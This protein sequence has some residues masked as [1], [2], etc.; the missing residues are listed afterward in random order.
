MSTKHNLFLVMTVICLLGF[1]TKSGWA[2]NV[3]PDGGFESGT[4]G[5]WISLG[6]TMSIAATGAKEGTQCLQVDV[7]AG[8]WGNI[9][10]TYTG[11]V[12]VKGKQLR[13]SAWVRTNYGAGA[14]PV[15]Y[16]RANEYDSAGA[17]L[18]YGAN[19]ATITGQVADWTILNVL[20][21]SKGNGTL[22]DPG[23]FTY[24]GLVNDCSTLTGPS[25]IFWD[26]VQLQEWTS[27]PTNALLDGGFELG[28]VNPWVTI[29]AG[30]VLSIASAGAHGGTN[31][32]Q[33]DV[34]A[35]ALAQ[36]T[37]VF[38]GSFVT[39][40][41]KAQFSSWVKTNFGPGGTPSVAIKINEYDSSG[42]L[43]TWGSL[44]DVHTGNLPTWTN[45]KMQFK[46]SGN[47]TLPDPGGLLFLNLYGDMSTVTG[48][49]QLWWDDVR[50]EEVVDNGDLLTNGSFEFGMG[51]WQQWVGTAGGLTVTAVEAA[52]AKEGTRAC[53]MEWSSGATARQLVQDIFDVPQAQLIPGRWLMMTAWYKAQ[54][55]NQKETVMLGR[56]FGD[57]LGNLD[58]ASGGNNG[59]VSGDR[60]SWT[61]QFMAF[62]VPSTGDY[63]SLRVHFSVAT[64]GA[65]TA[66]N[67]YV[68]DMSLM[69][70]TAGQDANLMLNGSFEDEMQTW[71]KWC[72]PAS[73]IAVSFPSDGTA[74]DGSKYAKI[75]FPDTARH[76]QLIF[77]ITS[78]DLV[79]MGVPDGQKMTFSAWYRANIP[80]DCSAWLCKLYNTTTGTESGYEDN[81]GVLGP[82]ASWTQMSLPFTF[83]NDPN[84]PLLR[85]I[86][87]AGTKDMDG[88]ILYSGPAGWLNWDDVRL[89]KQAV[90]NAATNWELY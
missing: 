11:A 89:E 52:D 16:L 87:R 31:C 19:D 60:T 25:Q 43:I 47:G 48:P 72:I 10:N 90:P 39:R 40:G 35:G 49:S 69:P 44:S 83:V 77:D 84:N 57:A 82:Q 20:Y 64:A 86:M 42:T 38:T 51:P 67:A 1:S 6:G 23:G 56:Y 21:T 59:G 76:L 12:I 63:K 80:A 54:L 32:L 58:G 13:L 37:D 7:D 85:L 28:N 5:A 27:D 4:T 8:Q 55:G 18:S 78:E 68:D 29:T 15:A 70:Y 61:R 75:E 46:L 30:T 41:K 62:R 81:G 22:P 88:A 79:S 33:M 3:L 74:K 24:I 73:V 26:D 9:V 50:L 17:N 65:G 36:A 2:Q 53:K 66:G 14:N 45:L 71:Q 34:P